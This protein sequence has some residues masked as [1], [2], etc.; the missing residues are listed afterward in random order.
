MF[1]S[2]PAC[3]RLFLFD[4]DG[5]LLSAGGAPRRAFRQALLDHFG[6]EGD[7]ANN[8]FSGKTDPQIVFEL[9]RAA[10][11]TD[12]DIGDRLQG[13]FDGYLAELA[14]ELETETRHRLFPG[15]AQLIP[16]LADD[17]RVV[18]GLVTGNVQQGARLKLDHFE[19]WHAFEVGAF[20]SD[21]RGRDRLPA[22][23]I[24]RAEAKT[25]CRFHGADVVVVGDTPA[26]IQCA[27]A[28]GATAVAVATGQPSRE[29]LAG[30]QPDMLLD[31]MADWP[32][33]LGELGLEMNLSGRR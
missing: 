8:D 5:T 33:W 30:C 1:G 31:S 28:V 25:G 16:A 29:T 6:T 23:A 22:I 13:L 7:A 3:E 18:L 21:D 17:S 15:V 10:G 24:D 27:R 2:V 4:I 32:K 9:M 12:G 19:L 20:G 11:F 26:D 14:I